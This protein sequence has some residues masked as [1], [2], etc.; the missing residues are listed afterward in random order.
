MN[1]RFAG[2]R[3]GLPLFLLLA[4]VK[5]PGLLVVLGFRDGKN[6]QDS[7]YV[8]EVVAAEEPIVKA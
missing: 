6:K 2:E 3:K 5:D 1:F 8:V 4:F 7:V